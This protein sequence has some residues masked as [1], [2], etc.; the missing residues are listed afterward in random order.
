MLKDNY[1]SQITHL[2][3]PADRTVQPKEC[4]EWLTIDTPKEVED[5]LIE[6]NKDH[7][8]QANATFPTT[9][10]FKEHVDWAASTYEADLI[11]NGQYDDSELN[12]IGKRMVKRIER[13]SRKNAQNG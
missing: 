5:Y 9:K 4:T 1:D 13:C 7:F 3:V 10:Q 2:Q 12:E 8:G 11:L 6:R